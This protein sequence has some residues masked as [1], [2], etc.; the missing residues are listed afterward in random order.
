MGEWVAREALYPLKF[1]PRYHGRIWGGSK[2]SSVLRRQVPDTGMPIGESWELV[3]REE[4]NSAVINGA[5]N[6]FTLHELLEHYG[7]DLTGG[8]TAFKRFPLL[9]K[10][11]DAGDR[12]SLQVHPDSAACAGLGGGAE[13]KTEMWYILDADAD[14][15]IMAGLNRGATRLALTEKLTSPEVEKLLQVYHSLPGDAYFIT[16]GTLHA[17][18]GGNLLLEIQQNSDTTYRVSDWGRKDAQGKSRE[19]HVEKG[20]KSIN[21]TDRSSPKISGDCTRTNRN[22]R[23]RVVENCP[24]F[25]ADDLRLADRWND[26]TAGRSFH[27]LSAAGGRIRVGDAAGKRAAEAETGETLLVP[28][29]FGKYVIDPLGEDGAAVVRTVL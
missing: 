20:L 29:C 19:L 15:V 7:A 25:R 3:D 16:S 11:I 2:I 28:A 14:A 8:R 6:G 10:L 17:I 5:L 26:D 18:G 23:F 9:V 24:Y 12:L 22:R 1:A 4:E 13:P 21:F 27:L